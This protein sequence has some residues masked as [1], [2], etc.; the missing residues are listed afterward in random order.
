MTQHTEVSTR[1]GGFG[2]GANETGVSALRPGGCLGGSPGVAAGGAAAG[3]SASAG[4]AVSAPVASAGRGDSE[5]GEA[6]A[7]CRPGGWRRPDAAAAELA[8]AT[9]EATASALACWAARTSGGMGVGAVSLFAAV[10][11]RRVF[12]SAAAGLSLICWGV[13]VASRA[14]TVRRTATKV[15]AESCIVV[16]GALGTKMWEERRYELSQAEA[17]AVE[18]RGKEVV[19]RTKV[20]KQK[21][22][23]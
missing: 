13:A 15:L 12:S 21:K 2:G 9:A 7:C 3:E 8:A 18:G 14:A 4:G 6:S 20:K 1:L 10:W 23:R 17:G 16:D 22:T 5:V 19:L 11:I